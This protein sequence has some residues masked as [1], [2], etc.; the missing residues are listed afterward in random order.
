MLTC[1]HRWCSVTGLDILANNFNRVIED[2]KDIILW[3]LWV[4]QIGLNNSLSS[5]VKIKI[6]LLSV[7]PCI[8]LNIELAVYMNIT[9]V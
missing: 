9:L 4:R 3:V 1:M 7:K 6:P 5:Y 8:I 2:F